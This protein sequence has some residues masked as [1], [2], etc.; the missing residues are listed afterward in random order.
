M[1]L[2]R[3]V[4]NASADSSDPTGKVDW[5]NGKGHHIVPQ[6]VFNRLRYYFDDEAY[7]Y[8][9]H[10]SRD[11]GYY[12]HRLDSWRGIT[13]P[14]YSNAVENLLREYKRL[15]SPSSPLTPERAKNFIEFLHGERNLSKLC[16][17][18]DDV[19]TVRTWLKGFYE[20]AA[21]AKTLKAI[22]ETLTADEIK[23]LVRQLV[24]EGKSLDDLPRISKALKV[25]RGLSKSAQAAQLA[26]VARIA[27]PFFTALA[28]LGST[29]QA[30]ACEGP[31]A[32]RIEHLPVATRILH[33]LGYDLV[34]GD[35]METYVLRP[36][37]TSWAEWWYNLFGLGGMSAKERQI[38][39]ALGR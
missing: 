9:R 38:H 13:H 36:A 5:D 1:N 24:N 15:Y 18:T 32:E 27:G 12:V 39:D 33:Q 21:H 31:L 2:Y 34:F 30:V 16:T 6:D 25:F 19:A 23:G 4:G 35:V 26:N 14:Q 22:D 17:M 3:Y 11:P 29:Q 37:A 28:V 8:V 10:A 20:S 7:D